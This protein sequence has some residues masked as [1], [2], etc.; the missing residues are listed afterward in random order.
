MSNDILVITEHIDGKM[1]DIS[2]EMVGQAKELAVASGGQAIAVT[3]GSGVAGLAGTTAADATIYVD[4]PALAEFNPEAYGKVVAALVEEKAPKV[5][6]F[7]ST[8]MGMDLAAWLSAKNGQACLAYVNNL[9][10]EGGALV[11]TSHQLK[12]QH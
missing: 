9:A 7:G 10:F 11:A 12:F 2:Y 8:S 4:D 1:T 5:T 3:L 6:M